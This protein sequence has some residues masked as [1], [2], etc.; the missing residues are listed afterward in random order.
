MSENSSSA[1]RFRDCPRCG[2]R[3]TRIYDPYR[4]EDS[5][6][7]VRYTRQAYCAACRKTYGPG[8]PPAPTPTAEDLPKF[9][10]SFRDCP[11]CGNRPSRVYGG[12]YTS[13]R[14]PARTRIT[15]QAKCSGCGRVYGAGRDRSADRP[16][17]PATAPA[18]EPIHWPTMSPDQRWDHYNAQWRTLERRAKRRRRPW[19]GHDSQRAK[20]VILY[21]DGYQCMVPIVFI[22]GTLTCRNPATEVDHVIPISAGGPVFD[23]ANLRASCRPCNQYLLHTMMAARWAALRGAPTVMASD[24]IGALADAG[25]VSAPT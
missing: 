8:R 14:D 7:R 10:R 1:G 6:G 13:S 12:V 11:H 3:P 24:L 17:D 22:G 25:E 2:G 23:P 16:F 9:L 20:D 18:P 21:R 5:L 19:G 4:A 15:R